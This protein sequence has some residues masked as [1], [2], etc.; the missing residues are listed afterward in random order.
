MASK[1]IVFTSL[2]VILTVCRPN[3]YLVPPGNAATGTTIK[4]P[5]ENSSEL[6]VA[7]SGLHSR[8]ESGSVSDQIHRP[9]REKS[10]YDFLRLRPRE[11]RE[12][13]VQ[14]RLKQADRMTAAFEPLLTVDLLGDHAN[15]LYLQF[16]A[17]WLNMPD[18]VRRASAVVDDYFSSSDI[19]DY[20]CQSG[21]AEVR[22]AAR[23][24]N[25]RRSHLI[26]RAQVTSEGLLR[27]GTDDDQ[28]AVST[29][30]S[31]PDSEQTTVVSNTG[32]IGKGATAQERR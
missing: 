17:I 32:L 27:T 20:L 5:D 15:I 13:A 31:F 8:P 7:G 1:I 21:F 4:L 24:L 6:K 19:E 10:C 23:G 3:Q 25:D 29:L 22:L 18:Y 11:Q 26:W 16:P 9:A 2:L 14:A 12:R 28:T 30:P